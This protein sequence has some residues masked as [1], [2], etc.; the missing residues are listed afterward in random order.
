MS[1]PAASLS[2][3]PHGGRRNLWATIR[4]GFGVAL[5]ILPHLLHH[6]GLVAGAALLT[7]AFGNGVLF[8]VGLLLSI[9]LLRRLRLRFHSRWAPA[10]GV[11]VFTALFA[12]SAFVIGPRIGNIG[13]LEQT[14]SAPSPSVTKP[15]DH[16]EH[17]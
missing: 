17:H 14:P 9:P 13:S 7:G 6:V 2:V 15:A 10:T 11:A 3:Q 4:A 16:E 8:L 1:A 5:G 12:L